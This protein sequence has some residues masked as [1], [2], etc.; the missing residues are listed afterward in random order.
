MRNIVSVISGTAAIICTIATTIANANGLFVGRAAHLVPWLY[1]LSVVLVVTAVMVAVW[2]HR[3][4]KLKP[5]VVPISYGR[6]PGKHEMGYYGLVVANHGEPAYD[7]SVSTDEIPIGTSKLTFAGNKPTFTKADGEA[8][9]VGVIE[10]SPHSHIM[11]SGLFEEMIKHHVNEI[12]VEL[13]YKDAENQWYKTIGK[14]ERNVS[15]PGGLSVRYDQQKRA[16]QP[17]V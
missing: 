7:V 2:P 10:V 9:F 11:G 16:K 17:K 4:N 6:S 14:I 15:A 5:F 3:E 13:I 1:A 12:T 8:F